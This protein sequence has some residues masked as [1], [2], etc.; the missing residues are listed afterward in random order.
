[1]RLSIFAQRKIFENPAS[2]P[3]AGYGNIQ[4]ALLRR[5]D[6]TIVAYMRENGPLKK[7]RIAESKDDG[8]SW[9]PV[10]AT[11]FPNPGSGL[12]GMR[13]A[14]GHWV[15]VCND[16]TAGRNSLVVMLSDDEGKTWKWRRHLE[17]EKAGSYHY[18]AIIQ[19]KDG[20]VHAVY[21]YFVAGGKSMKHAAFTEDWVRE[22]DAP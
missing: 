7:I 19:G 5:G 16:T 13:L 3:L 22:G 17:R 4:P 21:S 18:P 15:L 10:G 14:N 8:V 20:G 11:E 1:M 12:D 2:K 9:G 6:G